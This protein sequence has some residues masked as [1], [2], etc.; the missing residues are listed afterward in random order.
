M[1]E[2]DGEAGTA[3]EQGRFSGREAFR[4]RVREALAAAAR[5]GWGELVLSDASFADWPLG[6][7]EVVHS[8]QQWSCAGRR[9]TLLASQFDDLVRQQPRFVQWRRQWDHLIVCRKASTRDPMALPSVLW[10]PSWV[11]QRHD[12]VRSVGVAGQEPERRVALREVLDD[13]LDRKSTP[14]F[15]ASVLGL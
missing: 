9:F 6:E 3:L 10:S 12:P 7:R 15:P 1:D 5:D 4:Q 13:W 8:L 11:L 2:G 14:A